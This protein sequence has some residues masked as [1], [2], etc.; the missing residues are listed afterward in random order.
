L[1]GFA[2]L[3]ACLLALDPTLSH[4]HSISTLSLPSII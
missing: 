2:C 1:L 3:L 4:S